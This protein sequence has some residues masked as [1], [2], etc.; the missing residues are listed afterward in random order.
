MTLRDCVEYALARNVQVKQS[1]NTRLQQEVALS[2]ARAAR[3]PSLQGNVS[4]SFDFGRGLTAANTYVDRN[5]QS[6][7]FGVNA[8]V[9]LFTGFRLPN[10]REQ[11]R[12]DLE[13]ATADLQRVREDLSLQ[14]AQAYLQVLFQQEVV[15]Q[16][17]AQLQL[18]QKQARRVQ[19]LFEVKKA[20]GVEVSQA[21][22]RVAQDSLN[23][24]QSQNTL[25]LARLDLSQLIEM[26]SPDSLLVVAPEVDG[27]PP[28]PAGSPQEIFDYA[29]T[30]RPA[31]KAAA[32]RI[33]GA[34]RGERIA[35]SGWWPT[36]SLGAGL[37][38]SYYHVSGYESSSFSRQ[39]RDNFTKNIGL[40]LSIPIF[41]RLQTRN[42]VRQARLQTESRRWQLEAERK[43]L[44]KEI[45]QAWYNAVASH[46]K[47]TASRSAETAAQEA[48]RLM[49]AKYENGKAND[50]EYDEA[51]VKLLS[52]SID[53]ISARYD[54]LFRSK[55]LDFYRGHAIE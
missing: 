19:S 15:A 20:A 9:P 47:F 53:R 52:A 34:E 2:T 54:C 55:I 38:T 51:R 29:V 36:L 30:E 21:R 4:Q 25:L 39:M 31:M 8:S 50:T 41:D 12:L 26:P 49:E 37:G 17:E 45:Q 28:L 48:F 1:E 46:Q 44:Y 16:S 14:V 10:Q 23:L 42:N 11:A 5:T 24:V 43:T 7:S 27:V 6:T 35:K 40:T 13:A 3:L 33:A 22:S 18:S 32:L